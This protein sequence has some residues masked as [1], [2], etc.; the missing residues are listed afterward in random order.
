VKI[1]DFGL[2]RMVNAQTRITMPDSIFG[3]P[4]YMSPE[5]ASGERDI[6]HHTDLY[7][8]GV[9]LYE[10]LTG[11]TP[12]KADTPSAVVHQILNNDPPDPK[13]IAADAD[14]HL[15]ALALRL[16]AKSPEDRFDSAADAM[17]AL[18]ASVPVRPPARRRR[19]RRHLTRA[20]LAAIVLTGGV[21]PAFHF[22]FREPKISA[23]RIDPEL[24]HIVQVRYGDGAAWKAFHTFPPEVEC[25]YSVEILDLDGVGNQAVVAGPHMPLHGCNLF[26]FDTGGNEIWRLDISTDPSI[27]DWPDCT[28]LAHWSCPILVRADLDGD[29]GDELVVRASDA[30]NYPTRISIID[31][32][33]GAI[34]TTFWHMG[35]LQEIRIQ[36]DFFG[37]GRPALIAWGLNN[38]LDGFGLPLPPRPYQCPPGEDQPRTGYDLVSVCMILDPNDMNGLGPPRNRRVDIPPARPFAYAFL[39]M[40]ASVRGGTYIPDGQTELVFPQPSEVG[41][42]TVIRVVPRVPTGNEAP[43]MKVQI[44][45]A[46]SAGNGAIL[47]VDR[48]LELRDV[49]PATGAKFGTTELY[50]RKRWKLIIQNRQYLD[51]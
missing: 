36:P 17:E 40:P 24:P 30:H 50:W 28:A 21:W 27:R 49:E 35:Q 14:P 46:P 41:F 20:L 23:V 45:R 2:A 33:A 25:V 16:M 38:K 44:G 4:E 39:D 32:R 22:A 31:P 47:T 10:M 18:D 8:A 15:A 9:I 6:D 1:A 29:P 34:R 3:T 37:P 13:T 12:F 51:W 5:Q 7:S 19:V 48:N 42:I 43:W 26:T 11:R